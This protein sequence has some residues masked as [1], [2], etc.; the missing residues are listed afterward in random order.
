MVLGLKKVARRPIKV[1]VMWKSKRGQW[2]EKKV[3]LNRVERETELGRGHG[4]KYL[5][6]T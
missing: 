6:K 2:C 1:G 5:L 4:E 3:P